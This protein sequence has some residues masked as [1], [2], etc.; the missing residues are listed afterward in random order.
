MY[1]WYLSIQQFAL[2]FNPVFILSGSGLCCCPFKSCFNYRYRPLQTQRRSVKELLIFFNLSAVLHHSQ[3]WK[4]RPTPFKRPIPPA[5][6]VWRRTLYT[7]VL[8]RSYRYVRAGNYLPT[9]EKRA[10]VSH[11]V[12]WEK[13]HAKSRPIKPSTYSE[14]L[15]SSLPILLHLLLFEVWPMC[16]ACTIRP[17]RL[18]LSYRTY[19]CFQILICLEIYAVRFYSHHTARVPSSV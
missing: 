5:K 7:R 19:R 3:A 18:R 6:I 14:I 17:K 15:H 2:Y 12:Y 16:C 11:R 13:S 1:A 8:R 9:V 10:S 4:I